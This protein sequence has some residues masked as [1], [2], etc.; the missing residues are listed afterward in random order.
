MKNWFCENVESLFDIESTLK[1]SDDRI[2]ELLKSKSSGKNLVYRS[3]KGNCEP[4]SA[5]IGYKNKNLPVIY[6]AYFDGER[7]YTLEE[8]MIGSTLGSVLQTRLIPE[9][10]AGEILSQVCDALTALHSINII[11]RDIKPENIML[12]DDGTVKLFDFGASRIYDIDKDKDTVVL[13]TFGYAAPEQY[14]IYTSDKRTDIFSLGITINVMLTGMHP[15]R[16]LY[17]GKYGKLI[18]KCTNINPE[19][20]YQS[21]AELKAAL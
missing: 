7:S 8:Y 17:K 4:Y 12:T 20:R 18:S 11:H 3:F 9:S 2:I 19:K 21:A 5:L 14:G 16:F 15:S 13:G 1:S 6:D 10:E